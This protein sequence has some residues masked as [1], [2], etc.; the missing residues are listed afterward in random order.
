VR[1]RLYSEA[2]IRYIN[3]AGLQVLRHASVPLLMI[4]G[5]QIL[6]AWIKFFRSAESSWKYVVVMVLRYNDRM[7]MI[8]L[9]SSMVGVGG[10]RDGKSG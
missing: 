3:H 9:I 10:G 6:A 2:L 7:G 4:Y 5:K 8:A 1:S